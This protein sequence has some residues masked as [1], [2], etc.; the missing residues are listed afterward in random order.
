VDDAGCDRPLQRCGPPE[1]RSRSNSAVEA[2]PPDLDS[3]V[4]GVDSNGKKLKFPR[5]IP[6]DPMTGK[7]EWGMRSMQDVP[8]SDSW[9]EQN[10]FDSLHEIGRH[11]AG[12]NEVQGLV[13]GRLPKI[14]PIDAQPTSNFTAP[15]QHIP[16]NFVWSF[17]EEQRSG[18]PPVGR[19][20]ALDFVF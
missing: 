12:R 7:P 5:S 20:G 10:V 15:T 16:C 4:P 8:T 19:G 14:R 13:N 1:A 17:V 3:L 11:S 6:V 18:S 2:Y 9:G